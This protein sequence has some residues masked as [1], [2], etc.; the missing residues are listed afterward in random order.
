MQMI[1]AHADVNNFYP[2]GNT[3][4]YYHVAIDQFLHLSENHFTILKKQNK[5]EFYLFIYLATVGSSLMRD[6]SSQTKNQA[7]AME[8]LNPNYYT[9]KECC[10]SAF[11]ISRIQRFFLIL[12]TSYW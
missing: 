5:T 10:I 2:G 3:S 12:I 8:V 9:T 4:G 6:L 7:R 1:L 11:L